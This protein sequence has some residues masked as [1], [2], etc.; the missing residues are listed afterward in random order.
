MSNKPLKVRNYY[1]WLH[2]T[3]FESSRVRYSRVEDDV[4]ADVGMVPSTF[5]SICAVIDL[6][7]Q[8]GVASNSI[9]GLEDEVS[10]N[11]AKRHAENRDAVAWFVRSL[12]HRYESYDYALK[13]LLVETPHEEAVSLNDK[14]NT[15]A[16]HVEAAERGDFCIDASDEDR[17]R[18]GGIRSRYLLSEP[19]EGLYRK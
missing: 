9:R 2:G 1:D 17:S 12:R 19:D 11:A 10:M 15:L 6:D 13:H 7:R 4:I 18:R 3:R 8:R 5:K 14:L 16:I